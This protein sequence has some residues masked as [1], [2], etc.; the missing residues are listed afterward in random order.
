M[1]QKRNQYYQ[2]GKR[3]TITHLFRR[4]D[5]QKE[6]KYHKQAISQK[7]VLKM[8]TILYPTE[9]RIRLLY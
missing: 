8:A 5:F 3:N 2:A 9:K 1:L 4:I 7:S 6:P